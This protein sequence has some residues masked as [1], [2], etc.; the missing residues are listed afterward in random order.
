[1]AKTDAEMAKELAE[2]VLAL[3]ADLSEY[4]RLTAARSALSEYLR[5]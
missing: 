3:P 1:V 2:L 5:G 4:K